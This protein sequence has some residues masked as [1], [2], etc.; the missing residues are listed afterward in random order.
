MNRRLYEQTAAG[1]L[2][3][4]WRK[5][6]KHLDKNLLERITIIQWKA[7]DESDEDD[8]HVD[9]KKIVLHRQATT[10]PVS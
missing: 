6:T 4:Q 10:V 7:N 5:Q 9:E 1:F 2:G 8:N 3:E